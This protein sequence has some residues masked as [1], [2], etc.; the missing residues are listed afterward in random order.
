[1]NLVLEVK[2][3]EKT[4]PGFQLKNINFSLKEGCI[5]GLIGVNGAGKTTTIKSIL[6]LNNIDAGEILFWNQNFKDHPSDIKNRIGA[7]CF[8]SKTAD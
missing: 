4:Y 6:G 2:N 1:M 8:E 7:V 3:M 5:T